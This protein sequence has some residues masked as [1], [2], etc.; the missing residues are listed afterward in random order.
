MTTVANA[1]GTPVGIS[2]LTHE[3]AVFILIAIS[4]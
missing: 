1:I 3:S 4:K 2:I